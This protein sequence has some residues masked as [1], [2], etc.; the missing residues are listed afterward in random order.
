MFFL[1]M[2]LLS[3]YYYVLDGFKKKKIGLYNLKAALKL[4]TIEVI[5]LN[6]NWK[7]NTNQKL[8]NSESC[9]MKK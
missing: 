6:K 9:F 7:V 4:Y 3:V 8:H 2:S 5:L 1:P